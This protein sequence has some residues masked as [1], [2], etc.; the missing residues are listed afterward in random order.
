M[1]AT[2]VSMSRASSRRSR[3]KARSTPHSC[4]KHP[5]DITSSSCSDCSSNT[6][7]HALVWDPLLDVDSC[8]MAIKS[9][10]SQLRVFLPEINFTFRGK[11]RRALRFR[12]DSGP[13]VLEALRCW[14]DTEMRWYR[15]EDAC[16]INVIEEAKRR[17]CLKWMY[18]DLCDL[19]EWT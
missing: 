16:P 18:H 6:G 12:H 17:A 9:M 10:Q 8:S 13:W 3:V 15:D 5:M 2:Y 19:C 7:L 11:L 1:N 4:S 14:S